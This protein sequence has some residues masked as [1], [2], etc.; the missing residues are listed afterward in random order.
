MLTRHER[1][2]RNRRRD[3]LER[4]LRRNRA[5]WQLSSPEQRARM[6]APR[7]RPQ[8]DVAPLVARYAEQAHANVVRRQQQLRALV[9]ALVLREGLSG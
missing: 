8:V 5:A 6:Q 2:A 9:M 1:R 4:E 7:R 3:Q